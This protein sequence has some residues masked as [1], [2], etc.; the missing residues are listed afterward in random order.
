MSRAAVTQSRLQTHFRGPTMPGGLLVPARMSFCG[1]QLEHERERDVRLAGVC[2]DVRRAEGEVRKRVI[3]SVC[4]GTVTTWHPGLTET[5]VPALLSSPP[6]WPRVCG[7]A[8][9]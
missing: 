7:C 4:C 8:S 2:R 6:C 3:Q 1:D 9:G 5:S